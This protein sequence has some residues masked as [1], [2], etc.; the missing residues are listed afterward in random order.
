MKKYNNK[1]TE[2]SVSKGYGGK[3]SWTGL[4][5]LTKQNGKDWIQAVIIYSNQKLSNYQMKYWI[6]FHE[7][8]DSHQIKRGIHKPKK[9]SYKCHQ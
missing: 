9:K 5:S 2:H 1:E 3:K 4:W 6:N 7:M 8:V